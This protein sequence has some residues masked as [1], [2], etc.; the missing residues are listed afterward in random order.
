MKPFQL[1]LS[2]SSLWLYW[3]QSSP[4]SKQ[5]RVTLEPHTSVRLLKFKGTKMTK[6]HRHTL[7]SI[8]LIGHLAGWTGTFMEERDKGRQSFAREESC[9]FHTSIFFSPLQLNFCF[10]DKEQEFTENEQKMLH[11]FHCLHLL[12]A[13]CSLSL[14]VLL[15]GYNITLLT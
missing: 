3:H 6:R 2:D 4:V 9:F 5:L 1:I 13:W 11:V 7:Y 8:L 10:C 15:V 12:A 14:L